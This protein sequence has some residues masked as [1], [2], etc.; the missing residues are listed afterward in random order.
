MKSFPIAKNIRLVALALGLSY[1]AVRKWTLNG[2]VPAER[3]AEVVRVTGIAPRLLA[4]NLYRQI[5]KAETI[6]NQQRREAA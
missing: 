3:L 5:D 1:E 4:P 2:E 6:W